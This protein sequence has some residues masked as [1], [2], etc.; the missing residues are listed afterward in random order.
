MKW[1]LNSAWLATSARYSKTSSRGRAIVI[2]TLTG[3]TAR[4]CTRGP[5][6]G[7]GPDG[8]PAFG[9]VHDIGA[10]GPPLSPR[11]AQLADER[12][13]TE[14]VHRLSDQGWSPVA[15]ARR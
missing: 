7:R 8:Q 1:S 9:V 2:S 11:S 12:I 10:L 4:E 15:M 6:G 14:A 3:S 5:S 13:A